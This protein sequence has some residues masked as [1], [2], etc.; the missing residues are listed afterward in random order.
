MNF[1]ARKCREAVGAVRKCGRQRG[2]TLVELLV[3]VAIILIL[4]ALIFAISMSAMRKAEKVQCLTQ[5]RDVSTAMNSFASDYQHPPIPDAKKTS[6]M[7]AVYGDPGGTDQTDF[8]VAALMGK[9]DQLPTFP[10]GVA[11]E[12]AKANPKG[13][14]YWTPDFV[15][16]KKKGVGRH[17]GRY[18]D[19]WGHEIMFAI[20]TPP[21]TD[22]DAGG[23]NDSKLMT[24][25]KADYADTAPREQD[26]V[27]WS[28]GKDG[29][30]GRVDN[31]QIFFRGSDDVISW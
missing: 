21:Y 19:P 23:K 1:S 10:G 18:Y 16:D 13:E 31:G 26:F 12:A 4:A 20:N 8:V 7:D 2:F 3:V 24:Y 25:G 29:K 11:A 17:D 22:K 6:G 9:Q 5:I 30:M 14:A 15:D 27:V 28:Y